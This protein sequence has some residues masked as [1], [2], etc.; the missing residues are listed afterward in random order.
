MRD[1]DKIASQISREGALFRERLQTAEAHEAFAA[2]AE[3][4]KPDFSRFAG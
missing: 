2:F 1:M 3:R 4:R